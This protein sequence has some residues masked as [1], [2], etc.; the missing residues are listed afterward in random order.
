ME[1]K[2]EL[3]KALSSFQAEVPEIPKNK[4]GHVSNYASLDS[5]LQII[6]PLLAKNGLCVYQGLQYSED[7]K[8]FVHTTVAHV[9]GQC[10]ES[11]LLIRVAKPDSQALGAAITYGRR[12]LLNSMLGLHPDEDTDGVTEA[13]KPKAEKKASEKQVGLILSLLKGDKQR[14]NKICEHYGV[15]YLQDVTIAQAGDIIEKL[16]KD[17]E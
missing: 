11:R 8:E 7:G 14:V 2:Q 12:Y 3:Y 5:I 9:S 17:K 10:I 13:P 1:S 4:K 6:R 16:T 15:Q